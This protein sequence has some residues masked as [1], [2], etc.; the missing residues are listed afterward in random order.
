MTDDKPAPTMEGKVTARLTM[1]G[2]LSVFRK[3]EDNHPI[4]ALI[5]R[6]ASEWAHMEHRL[7]E[8]IWSLSGMPWP[9][10][11]SMTGQMVGHFGRYNAIIALLSHYD[12][13]KEIIDLAKKQQ[14]KVSDLAEYRNRIVH[15]AWYVELDTNE[16][17][18]Y[19]SM[20]KRDTKFG[21]H[22]YPTEEIEQLIAKIATRIDAI[23]SLSEKIAAA[24]SP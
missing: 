22:R 21:I 16:A 17:H 6:V 9:I 5:G 24:R 23:S 11:A 14:G 7:D 12:L 20:P 8:I 13:G 19:K 15:D 18:Q 4:Y 10:A 3:P 1:S 2:T